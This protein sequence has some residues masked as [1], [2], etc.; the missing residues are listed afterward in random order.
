M[1]KIYRSL[2][3]ELAL[4]V[5]IFAVPIF[6]IS[7]GILYLQSR[8]LIH[9]E[10]MES[11][12]SLLNTTLKR[13]ENYMLTVETA[14]NANAWMLEENFE[15]ENIEAVSHRI[16]T[17]NPNV[18]SCSVFA[19]PHTF[20]QY[21]EKY[22]VYTENTGD[23]VATYCEPDYDYLDK[24]SYT[25]P[26]ES[27]RSCWVD[28]FIEF[29]SGKV[30]YHQAI[31]TY[32]KPLRKKNGLLIGVLNVEFP[33]NR[34]AKLVNDAKNSYGESYYILLAG[35]GRY[36]MHPDT[37]RLFRKTIYTD[38]D[39]NAGSDLISLGYEMT[40]GKRGA[41]HV[42]IGDQKYH[43][44]YQPVEGTNWS[45]ALVCSDNQVMKSFHK[46]GYIVIILIIA[47]L[48]VIIWLSSRLVKQTISPL[49][50]L[51]ESTKHFADG[52]FDE[53]IPVTKQ[54]GPFSSLQNSFAQMQLA[55]DKKMRALSQTTEEMRQRND[56]LQQD[57][58]QAE[59]VVKRKN[60]FML[61][62]A[63]HM[64][65]PL[66]VITGFA[67]VLR[68]NYDSKTALSVE[69]LGNIVSMMK[70]NAVNL[71]R[72]VLMLFDASDT[73]SNEALRCA[74]TDEVS[75]N[76]LAKECIQHV[77]AHFPHVDIAFES[78]V[79]DTECILTNYVYALRTLRELVYNAAK[80]TD[81]KNIQMSVSAT[82]TM[83]RFTVQDIGPGVPKDVAEQIF[84][85]FT[86]EGDLSEG[87]GLG[88]P[89]AKRHAKSLGGDLVFDPEY[90]QGCR[91]MLE[92]PK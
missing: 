88:L 65:S 30:D 57:V 37:T 91:V 6:V 33:F 84:E 1:S 62:L 11:A 39:P 79:R 32:C 7:L 61:L 64:R 50:E 72:M 4:G 78:S 19:T 81:G 55:L 49:I 66:S 14:A 85:P 43:V 31:A 15:P 29:N 60:R 21:G 83:V 34:L 52:Q 2:S 17:L 13:V 68:E 71:G 41:M 3:R 67:Y 77:L 10:A 25:Q 48:F 70:N 53:M 5:T 24:L 36:L 38:V 90:H 18:T 40:S 92:L 16:V 58:K 87:L 26:V 56:A 35:D 74:R 80:Y 46:S 51:L 45:L 63:Q 12:E 20:A 59:E 82:D 89:L 86:R 75:C 9:Q 44:C 76:A 42:Y 22:S 23:T 47:G 27:G 73:D 8:Y 54:K 28:P 69:E